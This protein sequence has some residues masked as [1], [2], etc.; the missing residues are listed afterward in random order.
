MKDNNRIYLDYA[1]TTPIKKEVL[2]AMLPYLTERFGNPSSLYTEG[3]ESRAIIENARDSIAKLIN[4][5]RREI[6]FTSSGTE[7]D[8]WAI[9]GIAEQLKSKGSH[10]ITSSIEH[11]AVLHT[12][13]YLSKNGFEITYIKPDREGLIS[14]KALNEAIRPDT[15]LISIMFANNEIGTI[16]P[17]ASLATI[18]REAGIIFHTDA[19]QALGNVHLDVKALGIDLCSMSAHKIYGPKGIGALYIR[20]GVKLD[21]FIHGGAQEAN[22]RAGTE[23]IS[24]ILGFGKA[25]DLASEHLTEHIETLRRNRDYFIEILRRDIPD[26]AINGSLQSRLPGNINVTFKYVEGEALLLLLDMKGI[27]ISTGSACSSAS[28]TPSHVLFEIGVP[29]EEI[30]GSIRI[31]LGDMTTI[32]DIDRAALAIKES[33][34]KLRKISSVSKNSGW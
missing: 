32:A 23:N 6:F 22:K 29:I 15:I 19:V 4:A 30:H 13:E 28:L 31:S 17:I 3:Q 9:I 14:E 20:K 25:A 8:N 27:A 26:I 12:C 1:A 18:A 21:S 7:A 11:H 2:D 34:E 10:I 33:V 5:E 16:E 24:G